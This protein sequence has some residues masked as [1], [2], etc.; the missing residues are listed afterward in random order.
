VRIFINTSLRSLTHYRSA[1]FKH[2]II[3]VKYFTYVLGRPPSP[4][5]PVPFIA[6]PAF[7]YTTHGASIFLCFIFLP[8]I[9]ISS[10][11]AFRTSQN[12]YLKLLSTECINPYNIIHNS[13]YV[14]NYVLLETI[15]GQKLFSAWEAAPLVSTRLSLLPLLKQLFYKSVMTAFLA[16]W[17]INTLITSH[18]LM[19]LTQLL[20]EQWNDRREKRQCNRTQSCVACPLKN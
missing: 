14:I 17:L 19:Y 9:N 10:S 2:I 11:H 5:P 3:K 16:Y 20:R 8:F 18:I 13:R 15:L 1:S 6:F 7:W 12:K 4:P